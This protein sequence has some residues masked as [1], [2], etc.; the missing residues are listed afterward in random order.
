M[1]C[2]LTSLSTNVHAQDAMPA[3]SYDGDKDGQETWG[4]LSHHYA[5]CE[6]GKEQSPI[7]ITPTKD[8]FKPPLSMRY[9]PSQTS[10]WYDGHVI[11]ATP[12]DQMSVTSE[13]RVY[14]L[15]YLVLHSPS[16]HVVKGKFYPLEIQFMHEDAA[17]N[18]LAV[19][20]FAEIG[21]TNAA[22]KPLIE[23]GASK[24]GQKKAPLF[25]PAGLLPKERGYFSYRGSLTMPPCTE[26]VEWRVLKQPIEM[27]Q[28]QLSALAKIVGRNAR[29]TQPIYMRTIEETLQ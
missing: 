16:E 29:L 1:M 14:N 7:D 20:V 26:G 3:W 21:P 10:M 23:Y 12:T 2:A 27:S 18:R 8:S 25:D 17:G 9:A 19:A 11:R 4:G 5:A 15:K 24:A 6:M 22:I 13:T 28:E